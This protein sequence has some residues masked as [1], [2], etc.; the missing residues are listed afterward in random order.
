MKRTLFFAAVLSFL[1]VHSST[2]ALAFQLSDQGSGIMKISYDLNQAAGEGLRG[3]ALTVNRNWGDAE[4]L[5]PSDFYGP[6]FNLFIDFAADVDNVYAG[7][8]DG[9]PFALIMPDVTNGQYEASFPV[10]D[11]ALSLGYLD[12]EFNQAAITSDGFITVTFW[13]EQESSFNVALDGLRGGAIGDNLT[14]NSS[15]LG[16]IRLMPIPEPA[17][18][19]LLAAGGMLL[20]RKRV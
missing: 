14:V 18:M 11:F 4:V 6:P 5:C 7:V 12:P 17:T 16:T 2:F 15:G 8:G 9:H 20:R 13:G 3:L 10:H 19:I 1:L